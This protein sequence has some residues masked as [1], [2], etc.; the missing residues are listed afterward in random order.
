MFMKTIKEEISNLKKIAKQE[1]V[2]MS[3]VLNV[4]LL[5]E[6]RK[7]NELFKR[8]HVIIEGED[9]PSALESIVIKMS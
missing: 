9:V 1:G 6:Q 3:F 2:S 5:I 8:A 7:Q 4:S